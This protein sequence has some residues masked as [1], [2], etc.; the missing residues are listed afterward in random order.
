MDLILKI[1]Y[2]R[3]FEGRIKNYFEL[4]AQLFLW[5]IF[6]FYI[7]WKNLQNQKIGQKDWV[8]YI[9]RFWMSEYFRTCLKHSMLPKLVKLVNCR[10]SISFIIDKSQKCI[11]II[12]V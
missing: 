2:S 7:S 11:I 6:S 5:S 9:L 8:T 1:K 10:Q 3:A 12:V 4:E